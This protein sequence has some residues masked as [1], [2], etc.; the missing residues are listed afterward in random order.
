MVRICHSEARRFL[1]GRGICFAFSKRNRPAD[2]SLRSEWH[3]KTFFDN[4]LKN[5][6]EKKGRRPDEPAIGE[7]RIAGQRAPVLRFMSF[8]PIPETTGDIESIG[9]LAGQSVG[10]VREMKPAGTIVREIVAEAEKIIAG[11]LSPMTQQQRLQ[12]QQGQV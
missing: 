4:L 2:S 12:Q 1:S 7:T 3:R 10:L 9:L 11:R 5:F 8:P 6:C